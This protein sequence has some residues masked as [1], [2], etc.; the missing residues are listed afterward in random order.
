MSVEIQLE[1]CQTP[2]SA[3]S[4]SGLCETCRTSSQTVLWLEPLVKSVTCTYSPQG[5]TRSFSPLHDD[6]THAAALDKGIV[7]TKDFKLH[8][9]YELL[10]LLGRGGMGEVWKARDQVLNRAVA[11]KFLKPGRNSELHFARFVAE[12][13]AVAELRHPNIVGVHDFYPDAANPYISLEFLPGRSLA[14]RLKV[15]QRIGPWKRPASSRRWRAAFTR[16]MPS[17]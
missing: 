3:P 11:L 17:V 2:L 4:V 12:A 16:P 14:E 10:E 15:E 13:Q 7:D 6:P 5:V 8:S 1:I 9:K